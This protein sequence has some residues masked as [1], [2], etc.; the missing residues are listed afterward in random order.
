VPG[1]LDVGIVPV[2]EP[3]L[4]HPAVFAGL[5]ASLSRLQLAAW[6]G[7]VA[8]L[9]AIVQAAVLQDARP[10]IFVSYRRADAAALADDLFAALHKRGF[11]VYIDPYSTTAGHPFPK[12]L[13][14]EIAAADSLLLIESVESGVPNGRC[15]RSRSP[16]CIALGL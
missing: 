6:C 7:S 5:P 4:S 2:L 3:T 9:S 14:E 12:E 15:G 16:G 10:S 1:H 13:A 11:R 8:W